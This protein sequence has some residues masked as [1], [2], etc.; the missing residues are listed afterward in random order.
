M[1]KHL[2]IILTE[3]FRRV[4]AE[5]IS[6]LTKT[7]DWYFDHEWTKEEEYDFIN[8]LSDYLYHNSEARHEIMNF[9]ISNRKQCRKV[10]ELF[11]AWFG[12]K[13]KPTS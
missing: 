8:W 4:D 11:N 9:P 10:A 13:V 6:D 1:S 5:Y 12:W 7:E 2:D 3:M